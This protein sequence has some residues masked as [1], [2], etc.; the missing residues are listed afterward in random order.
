MPG[1]G[2]SVNHPEVIRIEDHRSG[3]CPK[4]D[5]SPEDRTLW[6][7]GEDPNWSPDGSGIA[8]IS[9][10]DGHYEIYIMDAN[11]SNQT[12]VTTTEG[13]AIDPDWKPVD[14]VPVLPCS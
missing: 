9:M 11:G 4:R 5:D 12:R 8:L 3:D 10:R 7:T 1:G 6:V 14:L 13:N 2:T